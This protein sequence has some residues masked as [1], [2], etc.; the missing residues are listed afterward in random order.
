[1]PDA[2][3]QKRVYGNHDLGVLVPDRGSDSPS[4]SD[5]G[6]LNQRTVEPL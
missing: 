2:C 3:Y 5:R 1:M 4:N 6:K